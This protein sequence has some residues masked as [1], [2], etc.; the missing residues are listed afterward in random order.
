MP[1]DILQIMFG[2]GYL[3][4]SNK[5]KTCNEDTVY[6]RYNLGSWN[7]IALNKDVEIESSIYILTSM[8]Q[9]QV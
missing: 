6:K 3:Q 7:N 5:V 1:V 8:I 9:T 2:R 4:K